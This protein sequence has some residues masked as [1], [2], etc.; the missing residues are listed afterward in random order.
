M[1]WRSWIRGCSYPTD[2]TVEVAQVAVDTHYWPLYEVEGGRWRFTV[3]P[4][5]VRP[6][7]DS[8]AMQG[9]FKH[10]AATPEMA[11]R[12]QAWVDANW[13]ALEAKTAATGATA[14][15]ATPEH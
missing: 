8:L 15:H 2:L 9:R 14:A 6:V 5:R 10:L 13:A 4:A 3:R 7:A 12:L 1:P 11:E